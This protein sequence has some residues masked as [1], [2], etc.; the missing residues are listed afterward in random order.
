MTPD[1]QPISGFMHAGGVL[2]DAVIGSMGI[3]QCRAV[4]SPKVAG[5]NNMVEAIGM[6]PVNAMVLF[7]SIASLLGGIGQGNYAA[8]NAALDAGATAHRGRV[9]WEAVFSGARGMGLGWQQET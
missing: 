1:F 3:M 8:A 4:I 2:Q 9:W 5:L 6:A 7:S